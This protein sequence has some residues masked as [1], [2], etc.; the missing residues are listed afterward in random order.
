MAVEGADEVAGHRFESIGA[1]RPVCAPLPRATH[2]G[3]RP[4]LARQGQRQGCL[5]VPPKATLLGSPSRGAAAK[6]DRAAE[7][8]DLRDREMTPAP[9]PSLF[10][11][12]PN[13]Q[14]PMK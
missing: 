5:A 2:D 4:A 3:C 1:P 12:R 9:G 6:K 8:R 10:D 7:R 14:R 11:A 13:P